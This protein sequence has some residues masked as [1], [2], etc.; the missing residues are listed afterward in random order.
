[1]QA[2]EIQKKLE[3]ALSKSEVIVQDLTGTMD[4]FQVLAISPDF[5]G[6]TMIE[7]HQMIYAALGDAMKEAIHALSIKSYTPEEWKSGN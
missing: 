1:M 5:E 2:S 3:S 7:Q 6:K 4:H